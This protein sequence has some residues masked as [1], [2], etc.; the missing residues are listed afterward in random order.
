MVQPK[1]ESL[2]RLRH[3]AAHEE[4]T[5][6]RRSGTAAAQ[7]QPRS[8]Q[9]ADGLCH[10]SQGWHPETTYY[11]WR[12]RHNPDQIDAARRCRELEAKVKRLKSL[13]AKLLLDELMLQV[14]AKKSGDRRPA[15]GR[16][17]LPGRAVHGFSAADQW[18]H[19]SVS[20]DPAIPPA[21]G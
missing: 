15:A 17:E 11:R 20:L 10:L 14:I 3:R 8:S 2:G 21:P 19:R 6:R 16:G 12:Q 9:R 4:A 1:L 5:H 18:R 7:S 13:V